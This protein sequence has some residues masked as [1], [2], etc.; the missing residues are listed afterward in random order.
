[1]DGVITVRL[2]DSHYGSKQRNKNCLPK[3]EVTR[4]VDVQNVSLCYI[5]SESQQKVITEQ[6]LEQRA[7][8]N[9]TG[10]D[11]SSPYPS[12]LPPQ[13]VPTLYITI[14][15]IAITACFI[16]CTV[17]LVLFLYFRNEPAVKATSV[18]LSM[19][20][21]IGCYLL[22]LHTYLLNSTLLPS[23]YKQSDELRNCMC[24]L[25][26]FLNGVG[27]P[28]ALILSTLLVKLL[29]VYRLFSLKTRVSKFTTSNLALAGYVLLLTSPNAFIS[30][31]WAT[32]DPYTSTVLFSIRNG[33]LHI[34]VLC[35]SIGTLFCG[36]SFF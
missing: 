21:F 5:S 15:Y 10:L 35:V 30:L 27:F 36:R 26:T 23:L 19:L 11:T 9:E 32:V 24:T 29:R 8:D 14:F 6:F 2:K 28:I 1:M 22:V 3:S 18:S 7:S 12:D 13:Y 4:S 25:R 16:I 34:S 33:S 20:I 31:L 17:M